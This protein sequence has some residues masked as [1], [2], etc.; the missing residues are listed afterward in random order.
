MISTVLQS[1]PQSYMNQFSQY[2]MMLLIWKL[3]WMVLSVRAVVAIR[4]IDHSDLYLAF[5]SSR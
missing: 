3:G 4:V 1:P 2:Y 5:F